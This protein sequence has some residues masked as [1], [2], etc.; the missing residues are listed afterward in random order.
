MSSFT[1]P[2]AAKFAISALWVYA[3]IAKIAPMVLMEAYKI[4]LNSINEY[5]KSIPSSSS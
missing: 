4:R 1:I 5:G 3:C 2:R